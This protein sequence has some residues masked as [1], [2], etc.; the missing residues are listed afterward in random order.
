MVSSCK[1]HNHNNSEQKVQSIQ[2]LFKS[3]S[4]LFWHHL[5][6][7]AGGSCQN[8]GTC[9]NDPVGFK[10]ECPSGFSGENCEEIVGCPELN[11]CTDGRICVDGN[12]S[13]SCE[14]P[15]FHEGLKCQLSINY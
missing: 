4:L 11:P 12:N 2:C 3:R 5:D 14:C 13:F 6:H 1:I 9:A 8:G 10:C 7:C 15:L